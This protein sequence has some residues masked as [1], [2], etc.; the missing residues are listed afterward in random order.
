LC[1][2]LTILIKPVYGEIV[3]ESF[4]EY[5]MPI[6]LTRKL[7]EIGW[8]IIFGEPY[9]KM[10]TEDKL[11]KTP[12]YIIESIEKMIMLQVTENVFES[13]PSKN[14]DVIKQYLGVDS[15]VE[16][17]KNINANKIGIVPDFDFS[18]V[19]FDKSEP[20]IEPKIH[21]RVTKS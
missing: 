4:P 7:P 2:E 18:N 13:I 19:L 6:N 15:F 10:F 9:I 14:R 3:N 8:M 5:N 1:K 20:I 16:S 17:G 12:C 21:R 11:L